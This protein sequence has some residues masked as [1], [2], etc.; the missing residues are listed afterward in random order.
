MAEYL[1][2][3]GESMAL[4][5][6]GYMDEWGVDMSYEK[7]G[8]LKEAEFAPSPREIYLLKRSTGKHGENLGKTTGWIHRSSLKKKQVKM[9][10]RVQYEKI[11]D[12]GLHILADDEIKILPV[13]NVVI[14]AGQ[15]SLRE[16]ADPLKEKGVNVHLIGGAFKAAE[17]DA[18]HAI[19]MGLEIGSEL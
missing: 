16:L 18:K 3:E 6:K 9:I 7:R 1:S 17:L 10:G 14:C 2:H 4:N 13:D 8:A 12:Q 15:E 11:D 19:K 5:I